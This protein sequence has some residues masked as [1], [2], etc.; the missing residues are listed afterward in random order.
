MAMRMLI[1]MV[2]AVLVAS[3]SLA[4]QSQS[5]A[6]QVPRTPWG[7]PDL[8]GIWNGN[9]LQGV[10]MQRAETLGTRDTLNDD[11]FAQRV[12]RR[13]S[14]VESDNFDFSLEVAEKFEQFGG[15]GGPVSPPP[16]WLERSQNVSRQAS[17]II[18]P[19]DGRLPPLTPAAQQLQQQRAADRKARLATLQG[20]EADHWSDRS[21][22]DRCISLGPL[23]SLTPKIYNS[24]NR[25]VQGPGWVAFSNEMIHE[26]RVIP[27]DGRSNVSSSIVSWMGNSVGRWEGDTLVVETRNVRPEI[28]FQGAPLSEEGR[29][30]ERF[31]RVSDDVLEYRMTVEDPKHWA[32]PWT[33]MLPLPRDDKYGFYEYACHEGN[34]SMFNIMSG[35]RAEE[36]GENGG[37][38]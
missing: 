15:V 22:Y 35:A 38:R 30:I 36:R 19:P 13:D 33:V 34:Y 17:F 11:E 29:L 18:D 6:Y 10:P 2:T 12:T 14:L 31:R 25:I 28:N 4:G 1:G 24:G 21:L 27:T 20:Q 23:G 9:D 3:V 7:D 37:T 26:T 32:E 5:S 8:Q 16:H